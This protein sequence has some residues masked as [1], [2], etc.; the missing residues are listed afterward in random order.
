MS[1]Q[2]LVKNKTKEEDWVNKVYTM[3][4]QLTQLVKADRDALRRDPE[5][6][7]YFRKVRSEKFTGSWQV[8]TADSMNKPIGFIGD[9]D[10]DLSDNDMG[11]GSMR[12]VRRFEM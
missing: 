8:I 4:L 1:G 6:E 5:M 12:K 3:S 2:I 7:S 11:T 10:G 9:R